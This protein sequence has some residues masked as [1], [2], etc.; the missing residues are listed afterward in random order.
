M[1][2][3]LEASK[4]PRNNN[5]K[6]QRLEKYFWH[7]SGKKK[8]ASTSHDRHTGH[9]AIAD[10]CPPWNVLISAGCAPHLRFWV[11]YTNWKA[12]S[13]FQMHTLWIIS[14]DSG[15]TLIEN[16]FLVGRKGHRSSSKDS[17]GSPN[18]LGGHIWESSAF[19]GWHKVWGSINYIVLYDSINDLEGF[20]LSGW[21]HVGSLHTHT[22][23]IT[24]P[25][26]AP[27]LLNI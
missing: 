16:T 19:E 25:L 17:R 23:L 5:T 24:S 20:A 6:L 4:L 12:E 11:T 22:H 27:T 2:R 15:E 3:T 10:F 13:R 1:P 14:N 9:P 26:L 21:P 18:L 7:F 8:K